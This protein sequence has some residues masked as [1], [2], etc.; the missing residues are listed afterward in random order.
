MSIRTLK[1]L[2]LIVPGFM[3][4]LVLVTIQKED[5][6]EL[7]KVLKGVDL[8]KKSAVFYVIRSCWAR[9]I[10]PLDCATFSLSALS[11]NPEKYPQDSYR[12][13]TRIPISLH[14]LRS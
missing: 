5:L 3:I 6:S 10:T 14:T 7:S 12:N 9:C 4:L 1:F 13:S 2:R 11:S 8:S